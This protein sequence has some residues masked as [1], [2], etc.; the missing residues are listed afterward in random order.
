[1]IFAFLTIICCIIAAIGSLVDFVLTKR[2]SSLFYAAYF[3]I[4]TAI[5][6]SIWSG[7]VVENM[8][9]LPEERESV[10]TANENRI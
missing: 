8:P 9:N 2:K 4:C 5:I 3:T 1:M 6:Y 10:P 7:R